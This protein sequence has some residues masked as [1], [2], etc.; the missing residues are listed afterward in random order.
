LE[1]GGSEQLDIFSTT[2]ASPQTPDPDDEDNDPRYSGEAQVIGEL[3]NLEAGTSRGVR[4]VK[5][6][7]ELEAVFGRMTRGGQIDKVAKYPGQRVVLK[8]GTYVGMRGTSS[9]GGATIDVEFVGGRSAKVHI[10]GN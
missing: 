1:L 9:S 3:E 8:D 4:I 2:P 10:K 5:S 7:S 6:Q